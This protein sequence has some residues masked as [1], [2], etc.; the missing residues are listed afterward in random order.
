LGGA[1]RGPVERGLT[2]QLALLDTLSA[3]EQTV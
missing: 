1:I 3:A 2:E